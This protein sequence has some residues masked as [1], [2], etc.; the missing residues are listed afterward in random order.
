[1]C[2]VIVLCGG[3]MM[4]GREKVKPSAGSQPAL[5]EKHQGGRQAYP[6][7]TDDSL[8]TVV[9]NIFISDGHIDDNFGEKN[10]C[11]SRDSNHRSPVFRTGALT[12]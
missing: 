8:S 6:H 2:S 12:T 11:H 7:P 3:M 5:L 9:L 4:K 10:V 1:M